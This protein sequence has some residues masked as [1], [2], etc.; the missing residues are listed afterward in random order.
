[1][2]DAT[3]AFLDVFF[4]EGNEIDAAAI[5]ERPAL[6]RLVTRLRDNLPV[7]VVLPR[8]RDDQRVEWYV[9]ARD[10]E[11][12]RTVTEEVMGFVG[13]SYAEWH[14]RRAELD[15]SD[16]IEDAVARFTRGHALRLTTRNEQEFR[17]CWNAVELMHN[18]WSQRPARQV[19]DQR[20]PETILRDFELAIANEDAARAAVNVAEL[21]RRGLVS[22]DNARFLDVRRLAA[23]GLWSAIVG[24][25]DLRTLTAGRRPWLVSEALI[26]AFWHTDLAPALARDG[27]SAAMQRMRDRAEEHPELW[28]TRGP[29]R[30]PE[31]VK[32]FAL[33]YAIDRRSDSERIRRLLEEPLLTEDDRDLIGQLAECS[34]LPEPRAASLA[35]A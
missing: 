9:L 7:P 29:L 8:R 27:I 33:R 6:A 19:V 13:P 12:L 24:R 4:G 23:Q 31:V 5:R 28:S 25:S 22:A 16:P 35:G 1:M 21:T 20:T 14:G 18:V 3:E 10:E 26:V 30:S 34:D 15:R 17:S 11:H 32:S 2:T